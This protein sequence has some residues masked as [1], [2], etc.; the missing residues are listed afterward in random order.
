MRLV[1]LLSLLVL[2]GVVSVSPA[3]AGP[4]TGQAVASVADE[5]GGSDES[6]QGVP[7]IAAL[8][9]VALFDF[10]GLPLLRMSAP[11]YVNPG[12]HGKLRGGLMDD[13]AAAVGEILDSGG[14]P[15]MGSVG[16]SPDIT[17]DFGGPAAIPE[18]ALLLLAAPALALGARRL[19]RARASQRR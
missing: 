6:E 15:A 9:A 3:D 5:S 18:P 10:A 2:V 19:A 1:S 4:V 11:I 7:S 14:S 8:N 17:G 12:V 13:G 16:V